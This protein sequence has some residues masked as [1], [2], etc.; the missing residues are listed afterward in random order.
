MKNM[1]QI[2]FLLLSVLLTACTAQGGNLPASD[3]AASLPSETSAVSETSA[4]TTSDT[5]V[6]T[7]A[8]TEATTSETTES[9]TAA[10]TASDVLTDDE[11]RQTAESGVNGIIT[12]ICC[13]DFDNDG[14][15]EA[16]ALSYDPDDYTK[17][18]A[19]FINSR[20]EM[21]IIRD[22]ADYPA[23][24]SSEPSFVSDDT[25]GV[26]A[27]GDKKF[28]SFAATAGSYYGVAYI[29]GVDGDE[30]FEPEISGRY[31]EFGMDHGTP[32]AVHDEL[33][34]FHTVYR[35][36]LVLDA[37]GMPAVDMNRYTVSEAGDN[38]L[39]YYDKHVL[40]G[41]RANADMISD[42]WYKV[43]YMT[44]MHEDIPSN[45]LLAYSAESFYITDLSEDEEHI[46]FK[47]SDVGFYKDPA[48]E[49]T[50][51]CCCSEEAGRTNELVWSCAD[52]M[53][54]VDGTHTYSEGESAFSD[55]YLK[56]TA[57]EEIDGY[58]F[59][60]MSQDMQ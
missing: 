41:D 40:W 51:I 44:S 25:D 8:A 18:K 29:Y 58:I 4:T 34:Y 32:V 36:T 3:T 35:N 16:F 31:R 43:C 45:Y 47:P 56:Y 49:K 10:E 19:Y 54:V 57:L 37:D 59:A 27:V 46:F 11:L 14:R 50:Y 24:F 55:E 39:S 15:R 9:E 1:N 20:G 30:C 12:T 38:L 13:E 17:P 53:A 6:T 26:V 21:S 42:P 2:I 5:T 23:N 48:T 22:T 60:D 28:F 52:H 7:S 33:H